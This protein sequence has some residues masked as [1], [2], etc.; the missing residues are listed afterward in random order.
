MILDISFYTESNH[1]SSS[2][3]KDISQTCFNLESL[4]CRNIFWKM[5]WEYNSLKQ[6]MEKIIKEKARY[7][8]LEAVYST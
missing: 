3:A 8:I 7:K 6:S 1:P 5:Y 4:T 2:R